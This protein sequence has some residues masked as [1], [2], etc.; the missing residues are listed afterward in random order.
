MRAGLWLTAALGMALAGAVPAGAQAPKISDNAVRIGLIL[1]MSG[2]YADLT[3]E[4]SATAARLAIEEFGGTVLGAPVELLVKDHYNKAD[5]AG[6]IAREWFDKGGVDAILD[7]AATSTA[8][9]ALEVARE[10]N[11]II[12]FNGPGAS[13][14]TNEACM[15]TSVHWAFDT[16]ALASATAKATVKAGGDS[17]FFITA[18]Y[19][20]G[21]ELERDA[22]AA[23]KAAGGTVLG[24]V[25]APIATAD[26]SSYLLQAQGSKAKVIGLANAGGDLL[27]SA[28]Q[29]AEFGLTTSG[30]SL[31]GLLTYIQDIHSLGLKAMQGTLLTEAFYWDLN[32]R[33]RTFSKRYFERM[34]KMPNMSQVGVYSTV[35]HYLKAIEKAGTDATGPVMNA[36]RAMPINDAFAQNGYIREDGR[37][38]HD[39]YLFRVKK[40]EESKGDWD[41]YTL[42]ATIPGDEAFQPLSQSRCPLIK[43]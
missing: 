36:M 10:K 3:G 30:Q 1:D 40:P 23:V 13:R 6:S 42:V 35:L 24:A 37:M 14:F 5:V 9:A 43:K 28:K 27:N 11:K 31:A 21:Q 29:A 15:A 12:V 8:L 4:G 33:S 25:R 7:V 18:D 16:Y 39:M 2:I 20:F 19:A 17:W 34:K 38:V 32:D 26:F 22:A 41:L